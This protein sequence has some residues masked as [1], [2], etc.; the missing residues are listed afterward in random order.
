MEI[1]KKIDFENINNY[2]NYTR[3]FSFCNNSY[4]IDIDNFQFF[5]T[6][7]NNGNNIYK[8]HKKNI[9]NLIGCFG[10]CYVIDYNFLLEIQKK[11]NIKNLVNCIINRDNRKTLERLL[12][13]IFEYE[14][15]LTNNNTIKSLLG[16]IQS[17]IYLQNKNEKVFIK[18]IFCGR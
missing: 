14:T 17:N 1:E 11:Y 16:D 9:N 13:C 4:K 12:S 18:K 6:Y 2:K 15:N 10:V 7:L 3:L 8:F 5:T